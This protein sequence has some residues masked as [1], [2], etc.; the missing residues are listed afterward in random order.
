MIR[1]IA[2]IAVLSNTSGCYATINLSHCVGDST[3]FSNCDIAKSIA[4]KCSNLS[5]QETIDCF[6]TQE[7]LDACVACKDEFRKCT[8]GNSYDSSVDDEIANWQDA[9]EPYLSDDFK[10]PSAPDPTRTIDR[11]ACEGIAESCAHSSQSVSQS[12]TSCSSAYKKP[13][14]ITSCQRQESIVSLASVCEIDGAN[15]CVG[16]TVMTSNIWEFR[17]C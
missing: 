15:S 17:N 3:E 13:A 2:V 12:V 16:K 8:L 6:C 14:D 5:K 9:C 10:T 7:R 11:D 4:L 1:P